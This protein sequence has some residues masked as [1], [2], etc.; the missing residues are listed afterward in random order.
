MDESNTKELNCTKDFKPV[1][2][3]DSYIEFNIDEE[4]DQMNSNQQHEKL[5]Q[6]GCALPTESED[7]ECDMNEL[8]EHASEKDSLKNI[9]MKVKLDL[10]SSTMLKNDDGL[11]KHFKSQSTSVH[12]I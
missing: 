5:R 6:S 10:E 11:L 9:D 12:S 3:E 1:T 8:D 4:G 7:G 2:G